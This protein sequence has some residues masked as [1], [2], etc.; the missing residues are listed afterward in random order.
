MANVHGLGAQRR[1][2]KG[3]EGTLNNNKHLGVTYIISCCP[4][5]T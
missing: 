4:Q 3:N 2:I 1:V 5:L